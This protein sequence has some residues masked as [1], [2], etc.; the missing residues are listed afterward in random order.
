MKHS[1]LLALIVSL[2]AAPWVMAQPPTKPTPSKPTDPK[3]APAPSK[4]A[5]EAQPKKDDKAKDSKPSNVDAMKAWEEAG[6]PG[7]NHK[8]LGQFEGEWQTEAKDLTP[9]QEATDKGTMTSKM[10]YGGRFLSMEY[11]GRFHGQF[12]RGGGMWGYNNTEKRFESTWAD[13]SGTMLSFM[14]G[15]VSAD[16]KV[17][18]MTGEITD[19]ASGK[20][21][22]QKEVT[23]IVGRDSYK[24]EF[25][26]D[27]VKGME[28]VFA[29]GKAADKKEEKK[30]EKP[31]G[32]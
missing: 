31:K 12:F 15:S 5:E 16:G 11:D 7:P 27:G 8:L 6:K 26:M 2:L 32:K 17:F 29:K 1:L 20:K 18:T 10:V 21:T 25:Y 23:T 14:T 13:S 3:A 22:M 4:K 9:G 30:D 19:P 28:I 24:M